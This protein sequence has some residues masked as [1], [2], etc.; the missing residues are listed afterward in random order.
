MAKINGDV[1]VID[2]YF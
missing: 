2:V 1:N